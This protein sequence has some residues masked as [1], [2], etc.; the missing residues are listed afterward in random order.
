MNV[1]VYRTIITDAFSAGIMSSGDDVHFYGFGEPTLHPCLPEFIAT[2]AEKGLTSKINTNGTRLI[3]S[4]WLALEEAGLTRCLVSVDGMTD[5]V[6]TTYRKGGNVKD[7]LSHIRAIGDLKKKTL[8]ELQFIVFT[9]NL[10]EINDFLAFAKENNA[11]A[12]ILKKPRYWDGGQAQFDGIDCL[13]ATLRRNYTGGTCQFGTDYGLV[14]SDG[15]LTVCT[16]DAMGKYAVGNI[17][18]DG[19]RLW[20]SAAFL[21]ARKRAS[22]GG[23]DLCKQCGYQDSYLRKEVIKK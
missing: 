6:Y 20:E 4:L 15:T 13:P 9:H 22:E 3:P 12:I 21:S 10:S 11:D 23:F 17:F 18:R 8:L 2:V 19:A 14:F 7:V 1:D 16:A 5:E